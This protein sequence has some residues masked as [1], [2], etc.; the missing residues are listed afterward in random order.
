MRDL[1]IGLAFSLLA[2]FTIFLF[3]MINPLVII[4]MYVIIEVIVLIEYYRHLEEKKWK[5]C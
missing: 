2:I 1:I 3:P 4:A 5:M